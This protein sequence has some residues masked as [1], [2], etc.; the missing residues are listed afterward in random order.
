MFLIICPHCERQNVVETEELPWDEDLTRDLDCHGCD[1]SYVV[2]AII[3][4]DH[5]TAETEDDF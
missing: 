3:T 2:R 5:E 1:K 4:I